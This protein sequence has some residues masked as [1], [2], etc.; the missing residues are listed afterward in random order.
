MAAEFP[1]PD[2]LAVAERVARYIETLD[3]ADI[4]GVFADHDVTIIE[5]FAPYRFDGPAAVANWSS[6]MTAHRKQTSKLRHV[7]GDPIDFSQTGP[8]AYFSLPTTWTGTF[9]DSSFTETGG[10]AFVLIKQHE[11][12]RIQSYGWAVTSLTVR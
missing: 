1:D 5:N 10:W 9:H 7:F 12:W 3:P 6:G 11:T 8:R 4:E 2:M